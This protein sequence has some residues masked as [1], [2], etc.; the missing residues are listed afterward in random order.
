M[1]II[2]CCDTTK[3]RKNK[4]KEAGRKETQF[5]ATQSLSGRF[6]VAATQAEELDVQFLGEIAKGADFRAG[7][8][9]LL[10]VSSP[11]EVGTFFF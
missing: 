8:V 7:E 4:K 5:H 10:P 2:E 6:R 1:N 11:E 9:C 3:Q